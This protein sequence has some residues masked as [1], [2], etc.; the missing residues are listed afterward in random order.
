MKVQVDQRHLLSGVQSL[1]NDVFFC[2]V[3]ARGAPMMLWSIIGRPII[4]AK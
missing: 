1:L 4:G 2:S 3:N